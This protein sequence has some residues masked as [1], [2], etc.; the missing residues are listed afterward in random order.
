MPTST[1][2]S[3]GPSATIAD[4][5]RDRARETSRF[6][7]PD[8]D[9]QRQAVQA[10]G[11]R[12][13]HHAHARRAA[14]VHLD[15]HRHRGGRDSANSLGRTDGPGGDQP[16]PAD[17]APQPRLQRARQSDAQR[18]C[19]GRPAVGLRH[20]DDAWRGRQ[21]V[22]GRPAQFHHQ[23]DPRGRP[24][25]HQSARRSGARN[26]GHAHF[27]LHHRRD[28]ARR[29]RSP[30]AIPISRPTAATCGSSAPTG[31]RSTNTDLRLR[32]DYVH[33][34][35]RP[36]D[37]GHHRSTPAIE[38]AFPDRFVRDRRASW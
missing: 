34:T 31:S 9:R 6:G 24:A 36:A 30:A 38:A 35:H 10:S 37:L 2:A 4:F 5:P 3:P 33:S 29:P 13:Q 12:C 27:R 17:L 20:A 1:A 14:R 11:R 26:A 19:R 8:G 16:R 18:Q 28:G 7:R 23:L 15:S 22:A 21:L 25:D 32:A